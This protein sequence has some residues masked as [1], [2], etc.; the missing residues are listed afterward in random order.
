MSSNSSYRVSQHCLSPRESPLT[1]ATAVNNNSATLVS[2]FIL[3]RL[4]SNADG[5]RASFGYKILSHLSHSLARLSYR[6]PP[7]QFDDHHR[8]IE[9]A[10]VLI[11]DLSNLLREGFLDEAEVESKANK[12]NTQ[13]GKGSRSKVTSGAHAEIN[14]RLFR[15]L[16]R[17]A[18]RTRD[19]AE[20]LVQSV[21]DGQKNI[22]EVRLEP[23]LSTVDLFSRPVPN[24]CLVL[25]HSDAKSR[26][27]KV[28]S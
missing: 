28:N 6:Q 27:C 1:L 4:P 20:E 13:K 3:D 21:L 2:Q 11:E 10:P 15:V 25:H 9:I 22:L 18:P 17:E 8:D 26:N 12:K 16:G 5:F 19:A 14:D 7:E 24:A 23:H